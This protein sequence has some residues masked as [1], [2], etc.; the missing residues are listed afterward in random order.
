M[1][2]RQQYKPQVA[3]AERGVIK[4]VNGEVLSFTRDNISCFVDTRM[5]N[6]QKV[7]SISSL[8]SQVFSKPKK[9]YEEKIQNGIRNVCLEKKVTMI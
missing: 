5:M 4:D 1:A 3:K 7:D 2:E 9:Y 6:P 8:F